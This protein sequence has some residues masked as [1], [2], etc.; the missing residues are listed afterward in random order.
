ML[1]TKLNEIREIY[2]NNYNIIRRPGITPK[3]TVLELEAKFGHYSGKGFT[4]N[5]PYIHYERLLNLLRTL[6]Q[7][8]NEVIQE[9]H[10]TQSD[11]IRRITIDANDE[12]PE[13]ITWER[14]TRVRDFE[15]S[16]YD[17]R[18]SANI[19]ET[20][21]PAD[22]PED[23][24]KY[25]EG[26]LNPNTKHNFG[27]KVVR[28]RTRHTFGMADGLVQIDLT[29]VMMIGHD[30]IMRTR[31]EVELEFLGTRDDLPVFN[32]YVDR[33]FKWLRGT[34]L[35]YTN[36]MKNALN[37]DIG[38]ILN[39]NDLIDKNILVEARNIKRRDLVYGGIVG[40]S[41]LQD[42]NV[43]SGNKRGNP[44]AGTSYMITFKADGLRKMMI[45][46]ST[47]IWLVYPPFE[48]NLVLD[49]S[50]NIPQLDKLIKGFSGT[51]FDGE[52]VVPKTKQISYWYLAFDCLAFRGNAAIQNQSYTER[53]KIVSAIA[54]TLKTPLFTVDTKETAEIKTSQDFFRLVTEFLAR[55]DE[56][57]YEQDG[58][59]FIPIDVVY[60]PY[61]QRYA[62]KDRSLT[63]IPDTCKWKVGT[64]I[65]IDFALRWLPNGRLDLYSFDDTQ[66][67]MVPFR[68]DVINPLTS[69]M[70]EYENELTLNKPTDLIVEYE[71]VKIPTTREQ[72]ARKNGFFR[73]RRIRYD[74]TGPNRLSIA[75]D[76]WEDIMN[77]VTEQDI[78]GQ[79]LMM[80][81]AYHNR[82]KKGLYSVIPR[83]SNI[84]D[85]GSGR[86]G[87]V[88]K[89]IGLAARGKPGSGLVVAVEPNQDNRSYLTNRIN[90]FNMQDR[91]RVVPTGG[92]DTI[93]IT[94]TVR[95]FIPGGKVDAVTLMLSMSFFWAS[96][97]HLDAL[98][99][100][101]VTNLKPGG[102]I[103]FLTINGDIVEQ[104]FEPVFGG[105]HITDKTIASAR[106]HLFPHQNIVGN[107]GVRTGRQLDITLPDT[108]VGEQHEYIVHLADFTSR[109]ARYGI[110]MREIHRAETEKLLSDDNMLFSS[111]FSYGYYVDED[112]IT[113]EH[114]KQTPTNTLLP[115]INYLATKM[116]APSSPTITIVPTTFSPKTPGQPV[117]P[118]ILPVVPTILPVVPTILPVVPTILPVVPTIPS[119]I[120]TIPSVI[121]T[122]TKYQIEHNQLPGLSVEFAGKRGAIVK[123]AAI[124]DDTYAPLTCTWYQNVVRI[125]TIGEGSCFIHAVEKAFDPYYQQNNNARYR[126]DRVARLR[127]DLAIA[128]GLDNPQYP[129]NT[130]WATSARG[131]FPRMVMQQINDEELIRDLQVDYTLSGLQRL[132]NSTSWLGDEVY[133]FI[134]DILGIDI[135]VLR[136]T[137]I[138]LY[139]HYHTHRPGINRNGIVVIGN[140]THYEVLALN[141]PEG[142]Q[143]VFP[144][145]DP[146]L[147]ALTDLFVG[148]GGFNDINN[149]IPYDPDE[150]FINDFVD[151]FVG[152]EGLIIPTVITEIFPESDPFRQTL[153]RLLPR[154]QEAARVRMTNIYATQEE[155]NPVLIQ[156]T[157]ILGVLQNAGVEQ[158]RLNHVRE[159]VQVRIIPD[160]PQ[161][162]NAILAAAETDGL[163]D[164]EIVEAIQNIQ[165]TM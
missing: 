111:M 91:V 72:E 83:G 123:G 70:I 149:M 115:T 119:V 64:D 117:V 141:K 22:I 165:L 113:L 110:H 23:L 116:S 14:K 36:T 52:L 98:V 18:V 160:I 146:F 86:G 133:T 157:T 97:A 44:K 138:D 33:I 71:W 63:R 46:H 74:K 77:P 58:L 84:L 35:V 7:V 147:T 128:L 93:A 143:T 139:P 60:N 3:G 94:N 103:I 124:N 126:L 15:L 19:E 9:S 118:T 43:L 81:F 41:S 137:S 96:D 107:T 49:L 42:P 125:A 100:T 135:Y 90:T 102:M 12:T 32:E 121:P 154:I 129:G 54:G 61:S 89:W 16:E 78:T 108:I 136:A 109:L 55:R 53:Q 75:L 30:K 67:K 145:G 127:R 151:T 104:I 40:N 66:D 155:E 28:D 11:N 153:D 85:I 2:D 114:I 6:P 140:R 1:T 34:N 134:S 132:F 101:I 163:L 120:P 65:T 158:E 27:P 8:G 73:P 142:F 59:M 10:V 156:L 45:I 29:E 106:F 25:I 21:N 51:V 20:L 5:V 38:R 26:T 161:D 95:E 148:D 31:Y 105:E 39:N 144:P 80:T 62:L 4:S 13:I 68:G 47:G 17:I 88:A 57:E 79:T 131:S 56:L 87:D 159:I 50:L 76:D 69:E 24:V 48:F 150:S 152:P 82:I 37:M 122:M 130:F 92:E 162:L 99:N 112:K 164:H